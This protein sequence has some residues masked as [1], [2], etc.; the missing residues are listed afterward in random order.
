MALIDCE[1]C[2]YYNMSLV[3]I[4]IFTCTIICKKSKINTTLENTPISLSPSI[5]LSVNVYVCEPEFVCTISHHLL[6]L[7]LPA[8][9]AWL[10]LFLC[11]ISLK[12]QILPNSDLILTNCLSSFTLVSESNNNVQSVHHTPSWTCSSTQLIWRSFHPHFVGMQGGRHSA[13]IF[14]ELGV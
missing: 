8:M 5:S 7:E 3:I 2:K 1:L 14:Y 12:S 11:R 10:W 13:P 4:C 6:E 9:G